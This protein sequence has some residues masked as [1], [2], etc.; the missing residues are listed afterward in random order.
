LALPPEATNQA[1]LREVDEELRRDQLAGFWE[2]YGRWLVVAVAA[3]LLAF[4]AFLYWQHRRAQDAG[5]EG[6]KLQSAYD[7]LAENQP[8]KA[9]APLA[10]LAGSGRDGYRALALFTQADVLLQRNDLKGAAAKFAAV[11]ADADLPPAFRDLALVR[12]TSAEFDTLAPQQVIDRLRPLAVAGN[13]Y[14]GSAGELTAVAYLRQGRRDLA[15]RLYGQIAAGADVPETIR[16]RSIQMAG[17]LGVDAVRQ[18]KDPS[19]Q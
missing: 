1:F 7:A 12:Q 5:A 18:G 4:A 14:L 8:A 16:Q 11:A 10:A 2:R 19:K 3:A 13:P 15:G 9:A 6:E 17:L